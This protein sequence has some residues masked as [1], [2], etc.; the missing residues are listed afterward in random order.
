MKMKSIAVFAAVSILAGCVGGG[1][2]AG[3]KSSGTGPRPDWVEGESPKWPRAQNVL[4]VGG[5]D[6]EETAADRARGEISRVFSSAV[7]VDTTVDE[8]ET[9]LTQGGATSASFSQVVA[10]K[11]QTASKKMLEGAEVVERWKDAATGRYYALAVLNKGKAMAAVAEKTAAL[12]ADARE[13]KTRLDAA[14]DKFE[15]AK[16]AA[17]L[18]A[19]LKGRLDLE[20]D[21]RVLGGGSLPSTVDVSA[22]KA[23]AAKA[24]EALDVVVIASGDHADELETGIVTGL[25]ASGLMAKRGDAGDAG[26]LIVES[27]SEARTVEGGDARWKWSRGS[28]TVTLKD[29]RAGKTFSRFEVSERQASADPGE[30]RRRAAS[31]LAKKAAEKTAAAISAFFENL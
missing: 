30:A 27:R 22:A 1:G 12:D 18:S 21:R 26:D 28:A 25:A 23:A 31:A 9:N 6:D 2:A 16:A 24:L 11:V 29:G 19:L 3:R 10:Q 15:R 4:G 5:G 7:S 14:V 17:K 20:N 8:T 13:W